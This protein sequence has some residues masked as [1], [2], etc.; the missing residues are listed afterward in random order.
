MIQKI[1]LVFTLILLYNCS[2]K[3]AE[4]PTVP[5]SQFDSKVFEVSTKNA[6]IVWDEAKDLNLNTT[7]YSIILND[8]TIVRN[9]EG[10]TYSLENLQPR[11]TYNGFIK[12][13]D[14]SGNKSIASFTFKTAGSEKL[15]QASSSPL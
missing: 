2:P 6:I 1:T 5:L 11:T 10:I 13:E 15:Q 8:K 3:K 9:L 12:A 7:H 4:V 14:Q